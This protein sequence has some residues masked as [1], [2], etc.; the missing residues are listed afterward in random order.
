MSELLETLKKGG[1]K[2]WEVYAVEIA[3]WIKFMGGEYGFDTDECQE[4]VDQVAIDLLK[5]LKVDS[6]YPTKGVHDENALWGRI[7]NIADEV[8]TGI[9]IANYNNGQTM[10]YEEKGH[11][12]PRKLEDGGIVPGINARKEPLSLH[13]L[14][15]A[16]DLH[17]QGLSYEQIGTALSISG[18]EALS[19]LETAIGYVNELH[20]QKELY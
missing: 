1:E 19:C 7:E 14:T 3:P 13:T 10:S 4:A 2:A 5:S 20:E 17:I 9:V 18:R 6:E 8:Y 15:Q 11:L 12:Q 16:V